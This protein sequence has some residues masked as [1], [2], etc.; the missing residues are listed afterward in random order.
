MIDI[1][2]DMEIMHKLKLH[3]HIAHQNDGCPETY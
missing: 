2:L 1:V 3:H